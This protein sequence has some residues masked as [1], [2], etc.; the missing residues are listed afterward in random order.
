MSFY[1][2]LMELFVP[3]QRTV[4]AAA[5]DACFGLSIVFLGGLAYAIPDWRHLQIAITLPSLA[6]ISYIWRVIAPCLFNLI[7][8][9]PH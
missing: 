1:V 2:L 9:S 6:G 8:L 4:V 3:E 5:S 7:S